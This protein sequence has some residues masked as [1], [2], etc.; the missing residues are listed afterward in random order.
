MK[1]ILLI[2]LAFTL[3]IHLSSQNDGDNTTLTSLPNLSPSN[4]ETARLGTVGDIA[5][6]RAAGQ[7]TYSIPIHSIEID[8][9]TWP[10]SLQ[11]NYGGFIPEGKPSLN[12]LGWNLSAFGAVRKEVRGLP[13]GDANGY[14]G[15][16]GINN[17]IPDFS[18]ANWTKYDMN[19]ND[20][21]NF[22]EKEYD[23]Q[24]DK[25]TLSI[26]DITFSFKLRFD[27][28]LN[29]FVP[30][31]LSK[32]N[33]DL[34]VLMA[35]NAI[36][37]VDKFILTDEKGVEYTFDQ[38]ELVLCEEVLNTVC[39]EDDVVGWLV[40]RIHYPNNESIYFNYDTNDTYFDW[41]FSASGTI[42]SSA[43]DDNTSGSTSVYPVSEGYSDAMTKT[44]ISR[45]VL[46]SISFP[47]GSLTF[48]TYIPESN[49]KL[50]NSI[51][52]KD[53]ADNV[54]DS[55]A[56]EYEGS[57][58][59]FKKITR[60]SELML[61]F[62]YYNQNGGVGGSIPGFY[63]SYNNKPLDQDYWR[64]YNNASNSHAIDLNINGISADKT[65]NFLSSRVGALKN[66]TYPTGGV[67][68]IDYESNFIREPLEPGEDTGQG[69]YDNQ[70]VVSLNPTTTNNEREV[71]EIIT[72]NEPVIAEISHSLF[73]DI[74]GNLI[75]MSLNRISGNNNAPSSCYNIPPI[76]HYWYP[77]VAQDARSKM[78]TDD[79]C[80]Y[81]PNPP[82]VP[83]FNVEYGPE[84]CPYWPSNGGIVDH[85]CTGDFSIDQSG[86]TGG[87]IVIM[88]GTYKIK[89]STRNGGTDL[90]P[91]YI[92]SYGSLS[93]VIRLKWRTEL[94]DNGPAYY[95]KRVGGVRVLSTTTTPM[96]GL[97]LTTTYSYKDLDGFSSG[98]IH[99]EAEESQSFEFFITHMNG[100]QEYTKETFFNLKGFNYATRN[101][102]IPVYYK[103]VSKT[104]I[105]LGKEVTTYDVPKE[106]VRYRFP[107]VPTGKDLTKGLITSSKITGNSKN[108][109]YNW[110]RKLAYY[111]PHPEGPEQLGYYV[112]ADNDHP[113]SFIIEHKLVRDVYFNLYN[114]PP[115][116]QNSNNDGEKNARMDLY[117]VYR[118][119]EVDNFSI[120]EEKE[121]SEFNLTRN[122]SYEYNDKLHP[123]KQVTID[124]LNDTIITYYKYPYS[125]I[126]S[127]ETQYQEMVADNQI[128]IPVITETFRNGSLINKTKTNY[129]EV[130]L[131]S[132]P[133]DIETA[134]GGNPL[135]RKII[136]EKYNNKG[137]IIQ[138]R[139]EDGIPISY[140][141]GYNSQ[142][143]VAK[144]ENATQAEISQLGIGNING[145]L[146]ASQ[147]ATL[148]TGL[149]KA[150]VSTYKYKPLVGVI[151]MTDS[152][153]NIVYYE[154][155]SQNR[156]KNVKDKD[157]NILSENEYNYRI[158]D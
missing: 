24:V 84:N 146:T 154:Y 107:D 21:I 82:M 73:G 74:Q 30:V 31:F 102:G 15:P 139:K 71:E 28:T 127:N 11:Y 69:G 124:A 70:I 135:E 87:S 14:Y 115:F 13:D 19:I 83:W 66:I 40:S 76:Q 143:V 56:L 126:V 156:L 38:H 22:Y 95:D 130:L 59:L 55:Y 46:N 92:F 35:T 45:T 81:F 60:N 29:K 42:V 61:S 5:I 23:S 123:S 10:I 111:R 152:R 8:G 62:E 17:K 16:N 109:F 145:A 134:K 128:K 132:K 88:P 150:L 112:D 149:P 53:K 52:L 79:P 26:G 96:D 157:G 158:N 67:T 72:F 131:G 97:P 141:W 114:Y 129:R 18:N 51:V 93:A 153:G 34:E 80:L 39:T 3:S 116:P 120:L 75:K 33:Y 98:V 140:L 118:Y 77:L 155:D 25:Y 12:G 151:S 91:N 20:F 7:M 50:F 138:V 6:N 103:R 43:V 68:E 44:E 63:E 1:K 48:S 137:Q 89:I 125:P 148:R 64:Y 32:H 136:Y 54:I 85:G 86:S 144:I 78:N 147:E 41:N 49:R 9:N 105:D 27:S 99:K 94:G 117:S 57:R 104:T 133:N 2:L 90:N 4:P 119:K 113:W 47:K 58:D 142:Y 65:P 122:V 100:G 106:E 121:I 101:A 37:I 108:I 36:H 110:N